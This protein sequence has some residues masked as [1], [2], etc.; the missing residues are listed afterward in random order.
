[1]NSF[2]IFSEE[3]L[4][5]KSKF[6]SSLKDNGVNEKEY[7]R[8][9][10]VWKL[11]KIKNLG[12]YHD[13]YLET[14]VLLLCDVF[15]RFVETCLNYYILDSCHYFSS[16]GLSWVAMLKITGTYLRYGHALIY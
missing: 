7:E 8:A 13:F 2:K 12:Q 15:E 16:P 6:F 3:K 11:F 4:P 14:D 9:V 5:D 10:N 1:M